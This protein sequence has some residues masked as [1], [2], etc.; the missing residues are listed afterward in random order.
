M[1]RLEGTAGCRA[2]A[3]AAAAA[4]FT[5]VIASPRLGVEAAAVA[6]V[7][8]DPQATGLLHLGG[9]PTRDA[10]RAI[11]A[12]VRLAGVAQVVVDTA[13]RTTPREVVAASATGGV[14]GSTKHSPGGPPRAKATL[15]RRGFVTMTSPIINKT[16]LIGENTHR[17][18]NVGRL[19]QGP[20][21]T[22]E[23]EYEKGN[24]KAATGAVELPAIGIGRPNP[25]P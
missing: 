24:R 6:V 2:V 20:G 23:R 10:C 8:G 15:R 25:A 3:A 17:W 18:G 1:R 11:A 19:T 14:V 13:R 4:G 22:G 7:A 5:I 9:L 16:V 12:G 21:P